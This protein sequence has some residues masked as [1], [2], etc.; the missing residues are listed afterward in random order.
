MPLFKKKLLLV[1]DCETDGFDHVCDLGFTLV[2]KHENVIDTG[3][4]LIGDMYERYGPYYKDKRK[5]YDN[6]I[7]SKKIEV[8]RFDHARR[9][10]L[11]RIDGDVSVWAYNAA[12]DSRVLNKMVRMFKMAETFLPETHK[13]NCIWKA[14]AAF[15]PEGYSRHGERTTSGK[16]L[17]SSAQAAFRHEMAPSFIEAHTASDDSFV[18]AQL[19]L[20]IIRRVGSIQKVIEGA[21]TLKGQPFKQFAVADLQPEPEMIAAEAAA[22]EIAGEHEKNILAEN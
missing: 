19:L 1:I 14:F 8:C 7:A 20:K 10:I 3:S 16:Y 9:K 21:N 2:D 17:S 11:E 18:E 13:F 22:A 6:L 15:K 5:I 4:F 12:F